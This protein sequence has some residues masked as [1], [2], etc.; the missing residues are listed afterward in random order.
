MLSLVGAYL[1]LVCVSASLL[2]LCYDHFFFFA[3]L[4]LCFCLS[5]CHSLSFSFFFFLKSFFLFLRI[6][7][8]FSG[9]IFLSLSSLSLFL[10]LPLLCLSSP[11]LSLF[12]SSSPCSLVPRAS[13]ARFASHLSWCT[14]PFSPFSSH[15]CLISFLSIRGW[16]ANKVSSGLA[17][18]L[19]DN[20]RPAL[21]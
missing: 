19:S 6:S 3:S 12:L 16:R 21:R 13:L 9:L 11:S 1:L 5:L 2:L 20:H 18:P 10:S 4:Y 7:R 17:D 8:W 14:H 15:S